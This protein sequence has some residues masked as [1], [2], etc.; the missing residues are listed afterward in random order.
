MIINV[1]IAIG[2]SFGLSNGSEETRLA[3]SRRALLLSQSTGYT[4]STRAPRPRRRE[5]GRPRYLQHQTRQRP[6]TPQ[7]LVISRVRP[8]QKNQITKHLSHYHIRRRFPSPRPQYSSLRSQTPRPPKTKDTPSISTA[9]AQHPPDV[10]SSPSRP[11]VL[12]ATPS[13]AARSRNSLPFITSP[14]QS[15]H[16][17]SQKNSSS[18]KITA[19]KRAS[20]SASSRR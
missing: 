8:H 11:P 13:V 16:M 1:S 19:K 2:T 7:H 4:R 3:H 9:P 18:T 12:S 10:F 20:N 6:W 17:C 14:A 15:H 5:S